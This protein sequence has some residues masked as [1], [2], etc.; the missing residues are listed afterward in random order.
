ML[1]QYLKGQ[2]VKWID[3]QIINPHLTTLGAIEISRDKYME[4]LK[5]GL[6]QPKIEFS[7]ERLQQ[8]LSSQEM[9]GRPK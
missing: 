1:C 6:S 5:L 4:E 9:Q 8:L 3:C 2:G 7:P